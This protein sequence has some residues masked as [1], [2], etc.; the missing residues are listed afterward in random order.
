MGLYCSF[1]QGPDSDPE[2]IKAMRQA[3]ANGTS[4]SGEI[5]NY[6]K[7]GTPFWN[8]LAITPVKDLSLIHICFPAE[9]AGDVGEF[10]GELSGQFGVDLPAEGGLEQESVGG[11]GEERGA[12]ELELHLAVDLDEGL[13]LAVAVLELA[14]GAD[15]LAGDS[16]AGDEFAVGQSD[17]AGLELSLIHI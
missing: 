17:R 10:G 16:G 5:L 8:D 7:S 9:A 6:R 13:G 12:G 2:T 14:A 11:G 3:I 1:L 4:F 15:D